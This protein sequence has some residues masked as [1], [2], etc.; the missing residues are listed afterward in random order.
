VDI[1]HQ[2][3]L[4]RGIPTEL[5]D[6]GRRFGVG[7]GGA[8]VARSTTVSRADLA[9][10]ARLRLQHAGGARPTRSVHRQGGA[11]VAG[12][13]RR[14]ARRRPDRRGERLQHRR[15][16]TQTGRE[17]ERRRLTPS[18]AVARRRRRQ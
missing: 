15:R 11:G 6:V 9:R 12:R 4:D 10:R 8:A 3:V 17:T 16:L 1:T 2:P 5:G 7:G 14:T 18:T 13:G